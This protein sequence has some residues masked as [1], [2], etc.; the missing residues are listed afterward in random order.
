MVTRFS[1]TGGAQFLAFAR[2]DLPLAFRSPFCRTAQSIVTADLIDHPKREGLS[3][4][5]RMQGIIELRLRM[6]ELDVPLVVV[7]VRDHAS[8]FI[9]EGIMV[10]SPKPDPGIRRWYQIAISSLVGTSLDAHRLETAR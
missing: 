8:E 2:H 1:P 5:G 7:V 9:E 6:F 4:S 3:I 10:C